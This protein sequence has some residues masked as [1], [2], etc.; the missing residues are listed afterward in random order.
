M[1]WFSGSIPINLRKADDGIGVS[2][3]TEAGAPT[4]RDPLNHPYSHRN[5]ADQESTKDRAIGNPMAR[6]YPDGFLDYE[7]L[8]HQ[9]IDVVHKVKDGEVLMP[10]EEALLNLANPDFETSFTPELSKVY[11]RIN[12]EEKEILRNKM[13]KF[14]ATERNWQAGQGGGTVPGADTIREKSMVSLVSSED[15]EINKWVSERDQYL[16]RKNFIRKG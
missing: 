4:W 3:T 15:A 5:P 13:S 16:S 6:R 8:M 12:D 10:T 11:I 9:V 1:S 14:F 7:Y 2:G